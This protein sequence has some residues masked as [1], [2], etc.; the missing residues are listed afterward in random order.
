MALVEDDPGFF[1]VTK[2]QFN[3]SSYDSLVAFMTSKNPEMAAIPGAVGRT[4]CLSAA[5]TDLLAA[6]N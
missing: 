6:D 5:Q 3:E 2:V 1:A 4:G